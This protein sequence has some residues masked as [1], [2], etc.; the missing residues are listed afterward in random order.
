MTTQQ[1]SPS[2][3][4]ELNEADFTQAL[5]R[6]DVPM[7]VDFWAPWCG[8]CKTISPI[9]D[10]LS[11][12]YGDEIRFIKVNVDNNKALAKEFNVRG[13]PCLLLLKQGKVVK[14]V[15]GAR[16]KSYY[17]SLLNGHVKH[18]FEEDTKPARAFRAFH[19]S[20]ATRREVAERVVKCIE[21]GRIT[22]SD[23]G[24]DQ[25][26]KDRP[27]RTFMSAP[28]ADGDV[29]NFEELLGIPASVGRLEKAV[30]DLLIETVKD[31]E[32]GKATFSHVV[33]PESRD[34]PAEWWLAV[35]LGADLQR[36]PSRFIDWLLSEMLQDAGLFG[37]QHSG[38]SRSFVTD[39]VTLH[40]RVLSGEAPGPH[41]WQAVR[42]AG[43]A[44]AAD[45]NASETDVPTVEAVASLAEE[46]TRPVDRV[47]DGL[48]RVFG[49]L[50][51]V[52]A[53]SFPPAGI[54]GAEWVVK[55]RRAIKIADDMQQ[56]VTQRL[57]SYPSDMSRDEK[58][59]RLN[60]EVESSKLFA[61][62]RAFLDVFSPVQRQHYTQAR[63]EVARQLHRGL[64]QALKSGNP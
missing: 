27:L 20:E 17:C 50:C 51:A 35:P 23:S 40:R 59:K 46:L 7:F 21:Q 36:L 1:V 34:L 62:E 39:L 54:S 18:P 11:Q 33:N 10:D 45:V 64:I 44:F 25:S 14:R 32:G 19:G 57:S 6:S 26:G 30:H 60:D 13:I 2:R 56:W 29:R 4:I 53:K 3:A 24:E 38:A 55:E 12:I 9:F 16:S 48:E 37:L 31:V 5:E 49:V 42:A 52:R 63:L 43:D 41:D 61:E 22:S 28:L 15:D 8:P 47:D 58:V